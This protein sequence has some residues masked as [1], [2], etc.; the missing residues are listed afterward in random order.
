MNMKFFDVEEDM[1]VNDMTTQKIE[2]T[3]SLAA[4]MMKQ[5]ITENAFEEQKKKNELDP[6]KDKGAGVPLNAAE[7][8]LEGKEAFAQKDLEYPEM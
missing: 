8:D 6:Y 2:K 7:V 1:L 5:A 3:D 4:A